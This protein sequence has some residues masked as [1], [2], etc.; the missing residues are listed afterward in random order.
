MVNGSSIL[1]IDGLETNPEYAG[2]HTY[3]DSSYGNNAT[4]WLAT[5]LHNRDGRVI[6]FRFLLPQP[7]PDAWNVSFVVHVFYCAR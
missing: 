6:H 4:D 5:E 2:P 3:F 7:T 1:D